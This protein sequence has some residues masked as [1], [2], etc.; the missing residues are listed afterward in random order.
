MHYVSLEPEENGD[1][2]ETLGK[3]S[4]AI[5]R[6][7]TCA[8]TKA[9]CLEV[10]FFLNLPLVSKRKI[11]FRQKISFVFECDSKTI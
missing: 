9:H 1:L 3:V 10:V 4:S 11:C 7:F 8:G 6:V 5:V 2:G